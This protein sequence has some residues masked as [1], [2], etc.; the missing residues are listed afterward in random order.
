MEF[1]SEYID[2]FIFSVLGVMSVFSVAFVIERI[3]FFANCDT[4][5]YTDLNELELDTTRN[6][7]ALSVIGTNAPYVGLLGTVV[8]VIVTFYNMGLTGD[9]ETTTI[10]SGLSIALKATALG[11]CV[12]IPTLAFYSFCLRAADKKIAKFKKDNGI[13]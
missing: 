10:M 13:K 11:L 1:L 8:G 4:N 2:I 6:L 12:A 5:K 7:T 3:V 9:F